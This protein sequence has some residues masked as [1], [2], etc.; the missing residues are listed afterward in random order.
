MYNMAGKCSINP[1]P[2]S[3]SDKELENNFADFFINKNKVIK[4]QLNEY[5]KYYPNVNSKPIPTMLNKFEPMS[6]E[7]S[8]LI[9]K[10][11]VSKSCELDVVPTTLLKDILPHIIDILVKIINATLEQ[12]VF[13]E[14]WK[15]AIVK[16]LMKK[17]GLELILNNYRP[18]SNLSFL[19]KVLEKCV[20]KQFDDHCK[21]YAL[22]PDYQSAYRQSHIC[23]NSIGQIY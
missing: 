21:K 3:D 13:A 4:D 23:E 19:T 6:A 18:A 10:S 14:K 5:P 1:L 2:D 16:P 22:L 7:D 11:M 12:G 17:L 15:V 9:I 8:T 20:L